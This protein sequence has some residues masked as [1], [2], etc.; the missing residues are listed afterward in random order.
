M[1]GGYH[2]GRQARRFRPRPERV[3]QDVKDAKAARRAEIE[4]RCAA[5]DPA[6]LPGILNHMDSFQAAIQISQ[7]LTELAWNVLRPRLL[8]Q[9]SV[10]QQKE[11]ECKEQ[12]RLL[13]E[14]SRQQRQKEAQSKGTKDGSD[15][16]WDTLQGPIRNRIG[17]LADRLISDH[18]DQGQAVTKE[19]SPDFAADILIRVRQQFYAAIAKED[20]EAVA[21]G[22]SVE[23]DLPNKPP[24]R[25]LLLENMKW[26]FEFKIK[27]LTDRFHKELFLCHGCNG[28]FRYY[29]FEGVVQHY[30]AKH[31]TLLSMGTV[32][33]HWRAE[34][35][36]YPLFQ[37]K[38]STTRSEVYNVP[39]PPPL[40]D[41]AF[42]PQHIQGVRINRDPVRDLGHGN[43][44]HSSS[45]QRWVAKDISEAN[46]I[47]QRQYFELSGL[48]HTISGPEQ[49]LGVAG[50]TSGIRGTNVYSNPQPS[51][52]SSD[53]CSYRPIAQ[54]LRNQMPVMGPS[55]GNPLAH[56]LAAYSSPYQQMP[57]PHISPRLAYASKTI[58]LGPDLY[59]RQ[60][61]EMAKHAKEVFVGIGGIKE[62]PG[63]VRIHVTIQHTVSRFKAIFP[64]APS[65]AMFIDGLERNPVMRPVRSVNG[66]ACKICVRNGL[67]A[68]SS[69]Q[70]HGVLIGD[71]RLYTLP[72]LVNHFRKAHMETSDS[73][74]TDRRAAQ[75]G[76][77][78]WKFDMIELPELP[79]ISNLIHAFGMTETK[80]SLIT[81]VFPEAFADYPEDVRNTG[82]FLGHSEDTRFC[83]RAKQGTAN[84]VSSEGVPFQILRNCDQDRNSPN[85]AVQTN[86][87]AFPS[88]QPREDEYDPHRPLLGRII[89][90]EPREPQKSVRQSG[91]NFLQEATRNSLKL[92]VTEAEDTKA[93]N[94]RESLP[95]STHEDDHTAQYDQSSRLAV[96]QYESQCSAIQNGD[97]LELSSI[98][99]SDKR[100]RQK[101]VFKQSSK[102]ARHDPR[103]RSVH[104]CPLNY[105]LHTRSAPAEIDA[106]D[107]PP[108]TRSPIVESEEIDRDI[109]YAQQQTATI[110]HWQTTHPSG[111]THLDKSD[112]YYGWQKGV[113]R[114]KEDNRS[115]SADQ[116]DSNS[117]L[118]DSFE[119]LIQP[120][121]R[122]APRHYSN[123]YSSPKPERKRSY[124]SPTSMIY[125]NG[126]QSIGRK[127]QSNDRS[128]LYHGS[129][130]YE[131]VRAEPP[132]RVAS[133]T[134]FYR[135][136]SPAEEENRRDP[137]YHI[138]PPPGRK[139]GSSP[140]IYE[141]EYVDEQDKNEQRQE[142][143]QRFEYLPI[144]SEDEEFSEPARY[145]ISHTRDQTEV[146]AYFRHAQDYAADYAAYPPYRGTNHAFSK[147]R[148]S[149]LDE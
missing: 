68:S 40:F 47:A 21:A 134:L 116:M 55:F 146:P 5:L 86:L 12:C 6:L 132:A 112:T 148:I 109:A 34:W 1:P 111:T 27:T 69:N 41:R 50:Q 18:W 122:A 20:Q 133:E 129:R 131:D 62:L 80:L 136:R 33:V 75:S 91:Q 16:N 124:Y 96:A 57:L 73:S 37:P 29:S 4:R 83:H 144:R 31:T 147:G 102:Q 2:H 7:P 38:P 15:R 137:L 35:P 44:V 11:R 19:T 98:R 9:V 135:T 126:Q 54:S 43:S 52:S 70:I 143:H 138:Y 45:D 130:Y 145:I 114:R 76:L 67:G 87:Q 103:P 17:P 149:Y 25:I 63:S 128:P 120:L 108:S 92:Q 106:V 28:N 105:G 48:S 81:S 24:T 139:N 23:K 93:S 3:F 71:R 107:K 95:K 110:N 72:H 8:A 39:D 32:V 127:R 66:I 101:G 84:G 88:D 61:D 119:T 59:R 42:G 115:R 123:A 22:R 113:P 118:E 53:L 125:E 78:D 77:H 51:T 121:H 36:E 65:L 97:S 64:A 141:Y 56:N 90:L 94:A 85:N 30:A 142:Y 117:L 99:E 89:K 10:A 14:E 104:R 13:E 26:L 100:T 79:V 60:M 49:A 46:S 82:S 58:A 74:E 140:K